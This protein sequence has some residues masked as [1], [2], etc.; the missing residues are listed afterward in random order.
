MY[1]ALWVTLLVYDR[2]VD[3]L[4]ALV[5]TWCDNRGQDTHEPM[6]V[7]PTGA[8]TVYDHALVVSSMPPAEFSRLRTI[9][10]SS[11]P[12]P[13]AIP[14]AIPMAI[15]SRYKTCKKTRTPPRILRAVLPRGSTSAVPAGC[16]RKTGPG[17][18]PSLCWRRVSRSAHKST[19]NTSRA[20]SGRFSGLVAPT[21][22]RGN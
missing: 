18:K 7:S 2:Q 8:S 10:R 14:T 11:E 12:W 6:T 20:T 4:H 13:T 16:T 17:T 3:K 22:D 15:R 9:M 1:R 21:Q 19:T 5:R